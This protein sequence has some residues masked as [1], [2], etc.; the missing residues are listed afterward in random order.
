MA[1]LKK[2]Y[3]H[4]ALLLALALGAPAVGSQ[5]SLRPSGVGPA[6]IAHPTG[7]NFPPP[8]GV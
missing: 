6:P 4:I 7:D 3:L 2:I 8:V 1:S 5:A